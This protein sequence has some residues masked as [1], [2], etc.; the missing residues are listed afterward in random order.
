MTRYICEHCGAVIDECDLIL[1]EYEESRGEFWGIPCSERMV[2]AHCPECDSEEVYEAYIDENEI[3]CAEWIPH[4]EAYRL[5]RISDV[6]STI[7][8]EDD[9]EVARCRVD[10][11]MDCKLVLYDEPVLRYVDG[12]KVFKGKVTKI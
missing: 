9:F 8:Y 3:V 4:M 11:E 5:Y 2:V 1:E 6:D 7:A 12:K 10:E